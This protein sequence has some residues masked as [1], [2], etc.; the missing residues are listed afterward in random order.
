[1]ASSD[2][3]YFVSRPPP[4][5][6]WQFGTVPELAFCVIGNELFPNSHL[7]PLDSCR[8]W[9]CFFPFPVVG[10]RMKLMGSSDLYTLD[11]A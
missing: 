10:D 9:A 11:T 8:V 1:M 2:S 6:R 7:A 5:F 4:L 3:Y